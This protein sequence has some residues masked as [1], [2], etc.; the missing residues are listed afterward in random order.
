MMPDPPVNVVWTMTVCFS[1]VPLAFGRVSVTP[2]ARLM[3]VVPPPCGTEGGRPGSRDGRTAGAFTQVA[4]ERVV[5]A[6]RELP[7]LQQRR[8]VQ[9]CKACAFSL[10]V[11]AEGEV[12][13]HLGLDGEHRA[14][15]E[16]LGY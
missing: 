6:H 15:G 1:C 10:C 3:M 16:A 14:D 13:Q 2:V 7:A 11:V 5:I 12:T 4:L 8:R 9:R